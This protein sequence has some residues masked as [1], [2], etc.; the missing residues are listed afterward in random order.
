MLP[1][2]VFVLSYVV[3]GTAIAA[4]GYRYSKLELI[5]RIYYSSN[6]HQHMYYIGGKKLFG[7]SWIGPTQAGSNARM[8]FTLIFWPIVLTYICL[9]AVFYYP[10]IAISAGASA[11]IRGAIG[12]RIESGL[13][14]RKIEIG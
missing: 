14:E 12:D 4:G 13:S 11:I 2:I 7:L 8:I 5:S 9:V 10:C 1:I 6:F 3:I